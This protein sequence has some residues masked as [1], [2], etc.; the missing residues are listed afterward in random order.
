VDLTHAHVR[1]VHRAV[2]ALVYSARGSDVEMTIVDG[3]IVYE[4]GRCTFVD[5][6]AVVEEA[7]ARARELVSRAGMDALLVP[8]KVATPAATNGRSNGEE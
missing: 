3:R 2:A 5:E 8:W 6:R 7:Q 1:P 4:G